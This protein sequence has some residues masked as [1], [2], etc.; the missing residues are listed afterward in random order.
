MNNGLEEIVQRA[1]RS[2]ALLLALAFGAR[3]LWELLVPLIPIMVS[4][5]LLS[6]IGGAVL[7]WR[8][9]RW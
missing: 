5:V 1:L 9:R 2:L 3:L 8:G 4:L 7:H 6:G